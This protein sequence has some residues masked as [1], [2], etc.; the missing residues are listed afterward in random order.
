[1]FKIL[2]TYICWKKYTKC[3]IWRVAVRPSYI[4]RTHGSWRLTF[5]LRCVFS[6]WLVLLRLSDQWF[7]F[8]ICLMRATL[9]CSVFLLLTSE[10]SYV[11]RPLVPPEHWRGLLC[12]QNTGEASCASRTLARPPVPPE[13]WRGLL[14][15]QNTGEQIN[16]GVNIF[17]ST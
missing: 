12:L 10:S 11:T 13:H 3:N 14:C 9:F 8:S 1:M 16:C 7:L 2:S 17:A 6:N 4:C 15:L 5:C